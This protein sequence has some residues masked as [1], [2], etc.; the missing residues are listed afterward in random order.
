MRDFLIALAILV[1]AGAYLVRRARKGGNG[2]KDEVDPEAPSSLERRRA[3]REAAAAAAAADRVLSGHDEAE[4][5]E[6]HEY[7]QEIGT[8]E[9]PLVVAFDADPLGAPIPEDHSY[10]EPVDFHEMWADKLSL[11][12]WPTTPAAP[13]PLS[14][15]Q[16]PDPDPFEAESF[17]GS[18]TAADVARMVAEA[19]AEASR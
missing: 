4:I 3:A 9:L 13:I 1:I 11:F 15:V 12:F 8:G 6:L 17:T 10:A 5:A 2:V 18:W 16:V 7:F 19:K 14:S